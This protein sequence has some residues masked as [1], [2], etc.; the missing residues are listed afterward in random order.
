MTLNRTQ[1][2]LADIFEFYIEGV[3]LLVV[4][5]L[6]ILGNFFFI[7]V[8]SCKKNINTFHSLMVS[9]AC[10]DSL[11]LSCSGMLYSQY[12]LSIYLNLFILVET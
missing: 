9:L 12:I 11:Y 7:I 6:G 8:F 5:V 10:F 1:D 4:A 2:T 3:M